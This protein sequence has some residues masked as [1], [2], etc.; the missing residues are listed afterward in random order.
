MEG[1]L[2]AT[3]ALGLGGADALSSAGGLAAGHS[4]VNHFE[5]GEVIQ[6]V[7]WDRRVV[8]SLQL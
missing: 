8:D 5:G 2:L 6:E 7:N 4:G 3:G 1:A